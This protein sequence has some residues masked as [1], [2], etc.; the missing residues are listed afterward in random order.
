MFNRPFTD[1]IVMKPVDPARL[2]SMV[3]A[4]VA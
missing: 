2:L 1:G 4:A 3:D